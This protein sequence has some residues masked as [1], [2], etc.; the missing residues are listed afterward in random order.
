MVFIL[1]FKLPST[2]KIETTKDPLHRSNYLPQMIEQ[3]CNKAEIRI[4]N[5]NLKDI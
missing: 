3:I 2:G 5:C 1:Y 4:F